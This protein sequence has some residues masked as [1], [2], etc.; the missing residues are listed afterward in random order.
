MA[1]VLSRGERATIN[2]DAIDPKHEKPRQHPKTPTGSFML[3]PLAR[4]LHLN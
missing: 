4:L 3:S 2:P 1:Q